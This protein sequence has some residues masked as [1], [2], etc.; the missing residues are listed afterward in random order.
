MSGPFNPRPAFTQVESYLDP[1][2]T[3][4]RQIAEARR[5]MGEKRWRRLMAEWDQCPAP[6]E[7]A[8]PLREEARR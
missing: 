1:T 2:F 5:R 6:N 3:L 7:I 4:D 8:E